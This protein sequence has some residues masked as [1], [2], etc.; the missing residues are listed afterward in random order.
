MKKLIFIIFALLLITPAVCRAE[1]NLFG[2]TD[3]EQLATAERFSPF[4]KEN[5]DITVIESFPEDAFKM[6][7]TRFYTNGFKD[8]RMR[9]WGY[10]NYEGGYTFE[11]TM[12]HE[13]CH[14]YFPNKN[15]EECDI[16]ADSMI[17][18]VNSLY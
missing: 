16:F 11:F 14:Y 8:I 12:N 6:G 2:T 15:E 3:P 7:S 9:S 10:D 18:F 5:I 4:Y 1:I 17:N 13:L